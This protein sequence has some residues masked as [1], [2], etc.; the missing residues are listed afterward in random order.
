MRNVVSVILAAGE[1]KRMKSNQSK[2]LHRLGHNY[3]VEF[4]LQACLKA[5]V[6]RVIMVIGHQANEVKK[7]LGDKSEFVYQEKRLGTGD[8]LRQVFPLL[9]DFKG[10]ILVLP[11]DA[12]FVTSLVLK[13]LVHHHR[14]RKLSATVVTAFFSNPESYG[15]IIRNGYQQVERIIESKNATPKELKIREVNSGIYCFKAQKIFPV[16]SLL[17]PNALSGEIY[18]T[19]VF[20]FF[21]KQGERVEVFP[22]EDAR[23]AMGINT[24]QDLKRAYHLFMP[25]EIS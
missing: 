7:A 19:D 12:P 4:P 22:V 17:K 21:H 16:L 5:G 15:R 13:N 20:E 24:P 23:I 11:G 18:L 3:L 8:A 10:E 14:K 2:L 25:G 9:S 6:G 1:S